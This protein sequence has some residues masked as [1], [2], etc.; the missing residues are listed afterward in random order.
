MVKGRG[1][2]LSVSLGEISAAVSECGCGLDGDFGLGSI[3][4]TDF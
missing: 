4:V 3:C 2:G 1:F